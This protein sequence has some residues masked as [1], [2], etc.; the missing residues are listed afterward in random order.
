MGTQ[1]EDKQNGYGISLRRK[2]REVSVLE[3][4]LANSKNVETYMSLCPKLLQ[5]I[6]ELFD[7]RVDIVKGQR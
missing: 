4:A 2:E 6:L 7:S 1:L 3:T 5:R